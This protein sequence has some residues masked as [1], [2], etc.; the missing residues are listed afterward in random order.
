VT[1]ARQHVRMAEAMGK[2]I[3]A[4]NFNLFGELMIMFTDGSYAMLR[5]TGQ[6]VDLDDPPWTIDDNSFQLTDLVDIGFI[7]EAEFN[8]LR[9]QQDRRYAQA[10]EAADRQ[11]LERLRAKYGDRRE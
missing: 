5:A 7:T 4:I 3:A 2:T 8:D 11:Q 1:F 6:D 10:R 9:E